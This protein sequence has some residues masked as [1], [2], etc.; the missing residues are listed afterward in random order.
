MNEPRSNRHRYLFGMSR[1]THDDDQQHTREPAAMRQHQNDDSAECQREGAVLF[2]DL[3]SA[4]QGPAGAWRN[5]T[6]FG[7]NNTKV[8]ITVGHEAK[9]TLLS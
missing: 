8:L 5:G 3:L 7:L 4:V 1:G 9:V 2:N 6:S